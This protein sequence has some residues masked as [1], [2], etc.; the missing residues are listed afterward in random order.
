[1]LLCTL[2]F[3]SSFKTFEN[4]TS[5]LP[6]RDNK[7][8]TLPRARAYAHAGPRWGL[9]QSRSSSPLCSGLNEHEG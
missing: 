6:L 1:M 2:S 4:A 5:V 9:S 7:R 8:L 3:R